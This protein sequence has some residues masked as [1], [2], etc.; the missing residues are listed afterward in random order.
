MI[1]EQF[2]QW[3]T[4]APPEKRA[5]ATNALARAYL[6]SHLS[7]DDF[8]AAEAAMTF[9]LDDPEDGVRLALAEALAGAEEAP[10]HVILGLLDDRPEIGAMVAARSPLLIDSELVDIAASR[11]LPFQLAVAAREEVSPVVSAAI[12]EV[13]PYRVCMRLLSNPNAGI[14]PR[15]L[16]RL[17]ERFGIDPSMQQELLKRDN[18]PISARQLI[19]ANM[20]DALCVSAVEA[21][22][23]EAGRVED[24]S[25]EARDRATLTLVR[26]M[27]DD[28][29][30]ELV[31][32]LR[33]TMQLTTVFLLRAICAGQVHLFVESL[34]LLCDASASRVMAL[35]NDNSSRALRTLYLKAGLPEE[36]YPAFAIAFEVYLEQG[37][38]L[39]PR[40]Q[41]RFTRTMI[42]RIL[43]RYK[44]V[45]FGEVDELLSMLRRFSSETA[46]DA[47]REYMSGQRQV[48]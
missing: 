22:Q 29:I 17:T 27:D 25:R 19:L 31:E 16:F 2:I 9:L 1:V 6:E 45:T 30:P 21:R 26:N 28:E 7:S 8:D 35:L 32:H 40:D 46:R 43:E 37:S 14:L 24:V 38:V 47:A 34:S 5:K 44:S 20:S 23:M 11:S 36:A 48:A 3:V 18:L 41:Y 39:D 15:T 4:T 10:R 33:D 42:E 12:A 13:T